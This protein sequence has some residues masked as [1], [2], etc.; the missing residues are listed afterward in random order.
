MPL[1]VWIVASFTV[2]YVTG[3]VVGTYNS[4]NVWKSAVKGGLFR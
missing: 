1:L 4:N 3:S 2:G